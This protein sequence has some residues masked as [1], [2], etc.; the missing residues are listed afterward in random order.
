[1]ADTLK[2]ATDAA[3]SVAEAITGPGTPDSV[4]VVQ[5][6]DSLSVWMKALSGPAVCGLLIA[7]ALLTANWVPFFGALGVWTPITEPIRAQGVVIALVV[8]AGCVGVVLWVAH[9][10]RPSRT[11]ISAG[12]AS[13]KIE[14]GPEQ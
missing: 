3:R 7:F 11:E 14:Q 9:V 6:V 10:G 1:M 4:K 5:R 13:I 12:P 2:P 8:L